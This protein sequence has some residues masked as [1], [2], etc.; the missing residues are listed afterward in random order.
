MPLKRREATLE[1]VNELR[2]Q[3]CIPEKNLDG[4]IRPGRSDGGNYYGFILDYTN[5]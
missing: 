3:L 1:R 4:S 2:V 5:S